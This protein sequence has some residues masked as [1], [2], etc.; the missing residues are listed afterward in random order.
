MCSPWGWGVELRS[1]FSMC[2]VHVCSI[3]GRAGGGGI[4]TLGS[5][6]ITCSYS[7]I[8]SLVLVFDGEM[9]P[10]RCCNKRRVTHWGFKPVLLA[11]G[12]CFHHAVYAFTN[13]GRVLK[14]ARNLSWYRGQVWI[15]NNI[16]LKLHCAVQLGRGRRVASLAKTAYS[17]CH[18]K[19]TSDAVAHGAAEKKT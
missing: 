4:V 2:W 7:S 17:H 10:C 12:N 3:R 16:L 19:C 1:V 15:V 8:W 6:I 5:G 11:P 9:Q 14:V 13:D 18:L